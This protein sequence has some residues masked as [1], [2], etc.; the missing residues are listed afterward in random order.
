MKAKTPKHLPRMVAISAIEP[1]A[2]NPRLDPAAADLP[3]LAGSLGELDLL[4]PIQIRPNGSPGTFEII[5]GERRFRA[6]KL[7]GWKE[8]PAVVRDDVDD[9]KAA[10]IMASENLTQARLN[11]IERARAVALL[12]A[13]QAEGG[14]GLSASEAGKRIGKSRPAVANVVR[15]LK[16]PPAWQER[17]AAGDVKERHARGLVAYSER[18]EILECVDED[19]RANP[20][21]W[22]TDDGFA[23]SLANVVARVESLTAGPTA[24][25]AYRGPDVSQ[26]T[27]LAPVGRRSAARPPAIDPAKALAQI[28]ALIPSLDQLDQL[29]TIVDALD[30]RRKALTPAP[31]AR[32]KAKAK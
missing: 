26:E 10:L 30:A 22:Q 15:L 3:A 21:D 32:R 7:A 16:L 2:R 18:P 28:L 8:I 25:Q 11:P 23:D 20:G 27:P 13:P 5:A 24:L 9:A 6:A 19:M 1:S 31:R 4:H 29:G 14:A 17:V 12:L